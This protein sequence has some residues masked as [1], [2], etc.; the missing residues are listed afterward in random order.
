MPIR[1]VLADDHTVIRQ[2]LRS[3]LDTQDDMKVVGEASDGITTVEMARELSPDVVVMDVTMPDLNG[4]EATRRITSQAPKVHVL[5]LS[6]H[7]GHEIVS[8]ML[9]AGA[10]AYLLKNCAAQELSRAI[11]EVVAG[12]A[13]LSPRIANDVIHDFVNKGMSRRQPSVFKALTAREREVLQ[14]LAEGSGPRQ[15]AQRLF[16]SVKTVQT[17]RQHIMEKLKI[18]N[19]AALTK[20]AIREGITSLDM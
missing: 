11:R 7:E 9:R 19:L 20:Y 12:H 15:I 10:S 17:H 3:F 1:I 4:V 18:R 8:E 14:L 6:M 13:Y 5:G 2:G 16:I